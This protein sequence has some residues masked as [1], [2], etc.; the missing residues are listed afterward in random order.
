MNLYLKYYLLA[1]Y[2]IFCGCGGKYMVKS[3]PPEAKV[4]FKD[5]KSN[6]KKLIGTT[7]ITITEDPRLGD[8]FFL[9]LEK[10]NYQ[11]KEIMIKI[12]QGESFTLSAKLDPILA[13]D[14]ATQKDNSQQAKK[15]DQKPQPGGSKDQKPKDWQLEFDDLKL[16]VV[17]L[18]N[19]T[20]FYKD[21]I[22]S[23][24][25]AG[26]I[27]SHERDRKEEVV[28][29]IFQAQQNAMKKN[30]EEASKLIDKALQLDELSSHAW[31]LKG[32]IKY[33]GNDLDGA[34][35]AWER[36]VKLDPFNKSAV[37]YLNDVYKQLKL[38]PLPSNPGAT[39]YPAN[40][41]DI[42]KREESLKT[43]DKK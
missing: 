40:F 32:S 8:V 35:I 28:N 16:R 24:R 22:F 36:A 13:P 6:E 11:S 7:P 43:R 17:L 30:Y 5:I 9:E 23:S 34:K 38:S 1:I 14:S 25:M 3:Y 33:L 29:F 18:E 20:S 27:P 31:L 12:N 21:A 10:D 41:L 19:T 42:E 4:Y 26:G 37:H 15:D 39:R 2:L